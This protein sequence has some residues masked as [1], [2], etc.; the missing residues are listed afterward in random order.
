MKAS[1]LLRDTAF[2][3]DEGWDAGSVSRVCGPV[4]L[5][6]RLRRPPDPQVVSF[7]VPRGHT[8][9]AFR[10]RISKVRTLVRDFGKDRRASKQSS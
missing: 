2:G 3:G 9:P 6:S 8:S 10:K 4:S 5:I 7:R 1:W